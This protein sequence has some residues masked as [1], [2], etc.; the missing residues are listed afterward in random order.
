MFSSSAAK[1]VW[2]LTGSIQIK[3]VVDL[4]RLNHILVFEDLIFRKS[5]LHFYQ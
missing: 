1:E 4:D 2:I 5:G 3:D